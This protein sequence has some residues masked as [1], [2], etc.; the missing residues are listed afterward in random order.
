MELEELKRLY[1]GRRREFSWVDL[2]L[3]DLT[4]LVLENIVLRDSNL[5]LAILVGTNLKNARL[6][7][8][9][10]NGADL[11]GA[12][13]AGARL[14]KATLCGANLTRAN[15]TNADFRDAN[16]ESACFDQAVL[17][18]TVFIGANLAG[19]DWG[20]AD[21]T[22]AIFDQ[23][24]RGDSDLNAK[25]AEIIADTVISQPASIPEFKEKWQ[26]K[27]EDLLTVPQRIS[28]SPLLWLGFIFAGYFYQGFFAS[29]FLK[30][31]YSLLLI[32]LA[33]LS[34]SLWL[35]STGWYWLY[36]LVILLIIFVTSFDWFSFFFMTIVLPL[37][38]FSAVKYRSILDRVQF[39]TLGAMSNQFRTQ[40][41][42][43][44]LAL[45]L[46]A[47][48]FITI[49]RSLFI[50]PG[51]VVFWLTG[52][53]TATAGAIAT[54]LWRRQGGNGR[55]ILGI[56]LGIS[57]LGIAVGLGWRYTPNFN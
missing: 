38:L 52:V 5:E 16:L 19:V 57:W 55:M 50:Q 51:V 48:S 28:L 40:V 53:M 14:V 18:N 39:T 45:G 2:R 33:I 23:H 4:G 34:P 43:D 26:Y 31:G 6:P 10:L 11:H 32:S 36:P 7:K 42:R 30:Q 37:S 56:L 9:N 13:L 54:D 1:A 46:G 41:I 12:N 21:L 29:N 20:S 25:I 47:V 44:G 35:F 17:T 8:A 24:D 22:G 27:P 15:L 49:F 3:K